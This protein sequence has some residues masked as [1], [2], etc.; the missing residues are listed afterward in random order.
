M[1]RR[2]ARWLGLAGRPAARPLFSDRRGLVLDLAVMLALMAMAGVVAWWAS[3]QIDARFLSRGASSSYFEADIPRVFANMTDPDSDHERAKVH[4]LWAAAAYPSTRALG[5]LGLDRLEAARAFQCGAG[6]LVVALVFVLARLIGVSRWMAWLPGVALMSCSG[7][8]MWVAVPETYVLGGAT[9]LAPLV[10]CGV[11]A[12]HRVPRWWVVGAG[13]VSLSVTVTNY[14]SGLI[15]TFLCVRRRRWGRVVFD[16]FAVLVLAWGVQRMLIPSVGFPL[17]WASEGQYVLGEESPRG[18]AARPVRVGATMVLHAAVLPTPNE[19]SHQGVPRPVLDP[20]RKAPGGSAG[21]WLALV[22]WVG[23]LA[24]GAVSLV[25]SQGPLRWAISLTL[26]GQAALHLV[27][28]S[29]TFLYAA[30]WTPVLVVL[31]AFGLVGRGRWVAVCLTSAFVVLAAA[32]NT[33]RLRETTAF[34]DRVG[35]EV[36]PPDFA[37]PGPAGEKSSRLAKIETRLG[38]R[39]GQQDSVATGPRSSQADGPGLSSER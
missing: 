10:V 18:I 7:W 34:M 16:T 23:L 17:D 21:A 12:T 32:E 5:V 39:V 20:Q 26:L 22:V 2:P 35:G 25:R 36:M 1:T 37:W 14:M 29:V 6:A 19:V 28:G 27:Y 38:L 9:L 15:A 33:R 4:P 3:G 31:T 30:H 24:L 13:V 8:M 11:A